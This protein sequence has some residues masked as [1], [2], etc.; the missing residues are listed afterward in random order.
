MYK[1]GVLIKKLKVPT[2]QTSLWIVVSNSIPKSIDFV[3]DIV[4]HRI[5][6][7]VSATVAYTYAYQKPSGAYQVMIFI[8]PK[9]KEGTIAHESLHA[10]NIVHNWHGFK[11]SYSNDEATAYLLDWVVQKCH[12]TIDQFKKYEKRGN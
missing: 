2:F 10:V 3:E 4:D 12:N 11:P 6:E 7:N 1:E 8:T 9:S 5:I